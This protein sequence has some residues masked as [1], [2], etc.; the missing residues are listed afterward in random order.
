M[1]EEEHGAHRRK[2]VGEVVLLRSTSELAQILM[3]SSGKK[4]SVEVTE[5]SNFVKTG[6]QK[7]AQKATEHKT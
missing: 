5:I 1:N 6:G 2:R 7:T 4:L 3:L